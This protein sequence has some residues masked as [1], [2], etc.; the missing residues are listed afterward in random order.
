MTQALQMA[1]VNPLNC[2]NRCRSGERAH[3][4]YVLAKGAVVMEGNSAEM[5]ADPQVIEGYLG[6]G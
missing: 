5:A 2:T 3:R 1:V 4:A 6:G